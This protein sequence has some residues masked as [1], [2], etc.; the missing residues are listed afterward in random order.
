MTI[1]ELHIQCYAKTPTI[2][3]FVANINICIFAP[4][5]QFVANF[6]ITFSRET[7]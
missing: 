1:S 4:I 5:L 7:A 2:I 3:Q 6:N